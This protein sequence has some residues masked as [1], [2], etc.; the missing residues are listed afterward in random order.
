MV[1]QVIA[2]DKAALTRCLGLFAPHP[3]QVINN[4][5]NDAEFI[6]AMDLYRSDLHVK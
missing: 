1:S 4:A 2:L 3:H 5:N 6:T